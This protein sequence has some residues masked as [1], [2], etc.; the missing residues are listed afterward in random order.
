MCSPKNLADILRMLHIERAISQLR[1]RLRNAT[2]VTRLQLG[3]W[4]LRAQSFI[5]H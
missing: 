1:Y 5:M 4:G 2:I 3:K